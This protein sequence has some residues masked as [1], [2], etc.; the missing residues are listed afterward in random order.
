MGALETDAFGDEGQ[1]AVMFGSCRLSPEVTRGCSGSL[2]YNQQS[3]ECAAV[4]SRLFFKIPEQSFYLFRALC[5]H[6]HK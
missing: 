1:V 3:D 4:I 5:F 2:K 6:A